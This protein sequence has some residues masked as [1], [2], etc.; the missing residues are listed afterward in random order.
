[1]GLLARKQLREFHLFSI[2]KANPASLPLFF[3]QGN[4]SKLSSKLFTAANPVSENFTD[5]E[6]S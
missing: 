6:N 1:M 4:I 5:P 3:C 2:L